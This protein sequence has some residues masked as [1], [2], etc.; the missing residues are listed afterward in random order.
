[1]LSGRPSSR[2][3]DLGCSGGLLAERLRAQGHHVTGVDVDEVP[4]VLDRT[5]R[6]LVADLTLGLPSDLDGQYDVVIAGDV[7]EHLVDPARL[8]REV[9]AQLAPGGELIVSV[10]N[11]AHWYP[12][13]RMALGLFGYDRRGPLDSTHLRFF[14]KRTLR[15]FVARTGFDVVEED[16]TPVPVNVVTSRRG[17]VLGLAERVE[18]GLRRAR[19]QLF[20]YQFILRLR[21]HAEGME[22]SV[23]SGAT[24]PVEVPLPHRL[25]A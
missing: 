5:D 16:S 7:L 2:F 17:P 14:T 25:P 22:M 3:L 18:S 9:A 8:M 23:F 20:A 10:P 1:M 13:T 11:V 24:T 15:A 4:G 21:P 19:P 12:R 6:F